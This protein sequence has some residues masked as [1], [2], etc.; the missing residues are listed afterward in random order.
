MNYNEDD[1]AQRLCDIFETETNGQVNISYINTT[2][3]IV[4]WH[5]HNIQTD[6][7]ICL[8]G[9]LKVG[10]ATEEDGYTFEYLS[11]KYLRVLKIVPGVYHGYKALEPNTILMYYVTEKY[12]PEDEIR[13]KVGDFGE[14]WG[15]VNK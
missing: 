14:E 8:K 15:I 5:K 9:S 3:H 12:N 2:E 1:R 7:W 6:Y 13:K 11:D 10:L 4:A